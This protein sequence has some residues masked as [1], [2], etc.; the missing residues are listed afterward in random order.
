MLRCTVCGQEMEEESFYDLG[1]ES[2]THDG[3][4][5]YFCSPYCKETF[6]KDPDAYRHGP[7]PKANHH[8]H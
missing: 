1:G 4:T 7:Q 5:Y 8:G 2:L 6:A 3:Q